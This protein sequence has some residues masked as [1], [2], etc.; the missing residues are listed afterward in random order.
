[1]QIKKNP[2]DLKLKTED[3]ITSLKQPDIL[4]EGIA[5]LYEL[6]FSGD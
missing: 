3:M 4:N 5:Q 2:A 6:I 1:M